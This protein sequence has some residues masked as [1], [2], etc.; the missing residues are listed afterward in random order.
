MNQ[1]MINNWNKVVGKNDEVY[2]LGDVG[3]LDEDSLF[4]IISK[5]NGRKHLIWGNHD[6]TIKRSEKI[7]NLFVWCKDYY[8][9]KRD[10]H[11]V[12]LFHYPIG[13]WNKAHRGAYHLHGHC[14]GNYVYPREGR[15]MDV[16]A[17][18]IGHTPI[19]FNEIITRLVNK[20]LLQH[21]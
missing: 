12:A 13:E 19:E 6:Q 1:A 21:H 18:L 8:E 2:H 5:L 4:A 9:L 14:H 7:R 17:N 15:N 16:G 3:F 11:M 10:G 20:P